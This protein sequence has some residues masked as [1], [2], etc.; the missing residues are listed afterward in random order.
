[1]FL[2]WDKVREIGIDLKKLNNKEIIL[3]IT[4]IMN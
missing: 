3:T 4:P 2:A 1:M